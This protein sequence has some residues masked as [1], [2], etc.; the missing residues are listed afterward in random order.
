MEDEVER[1]Q[2][3]V[4]TRWMNSK[5]DRPCLFLENQAFVCTCTKLTS[6]LQVRGIVVKEGD[7]EGTLLKG[8]L[9]DGYI[10][11]QLCEV[12]SGETLPRYVNEIVRVH[13]FG[14]YY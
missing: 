14:S 12:I 13:V 7:A 10:L 4:F 11:H 9:D 1:A 3:K 8:A 6:R 5:Y 2:A